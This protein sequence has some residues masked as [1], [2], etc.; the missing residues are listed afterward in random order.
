M[1][2]HSQVSTD[3]RTILDLSSSCFPAVEG[4]AALVTL[5]SATRVTKFA[6]SRSGEE[7]GFTL[8]TGDEGEY[9]RERCLIGKSGIVPPKCN[10]RPAVT[11]L[12]E[13]Y[14]VG[15][16]VGLAII[17]EEA[18]RPDMMDRE[19]R[20]GN[21][22]SLTRLFI[23]MSCCSSLSPPIRSTVLGTA[24]DPRW[25]VFSAPFCGRTP[26]CE[27]FSIAEIPIGDRAW[28]LLDRGVA[29]MAMDDNPF[30]TDPLSMNALPFRITAKSAKRICRQGDMVASAEDRYTTLSTS[31]F[32]H[33]MIIRSMDDLIKRA[34]CNG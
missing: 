8:P 24:S 4:L 21:P 17:P 23:S 33:P 6:G 31:Y 15:E 32:F 30:P 34:I 7:V 11:S 10:L 9:G 26:S 28:H 13:S 19:T 3:P 1:R 2:S 22:A 5:R 25:V 14:E 29:G 20:L 16:S 12:T 18:E 27:A